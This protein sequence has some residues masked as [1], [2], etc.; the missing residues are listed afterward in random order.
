MTAATG[1]AVGSLRLIDVVL[2]G[3]DIPTDLIVTDGRISA[4]GRLDGSPDGG[5]VGRPSSAQNPGLP[6]IDG[7]GMYAIPGLVDCHAHLDKTL[8]GSPYVPNPGGQDVIEIS[9]HERRVR[10]ARAATLAD[11]VRLLLDRLVGLGTSHIRSHVDIDTEAGLTNFEAVAA[12]R[13]EF[14]D[15]LDIEIVAFPQSGLL[16]RPGTLELMA[17]AMAAGADVVGGLDPAGVD[18]DPS[19]HLD[20][21]FG[22]ATRFSRPIDIHLHDPGELGGWEIAAI[23]ERTRALGMAGMVTISHAMALGEVPPAMLDRLLTG[24]AEQAVAIATVAPGRGLMLPLKR[25]IEAGV[26]VGSGNDGVRGMWAPYGDGDMLDRARVVAYRAGFR[27][28]ADI[29]LALDTATYGGATAM[30]IADYG[31]HLGA[32]ADFLLVPGETR[33]E[34]VVSSPPRAV[35]VKHGHVVAGSTPSAAASVRRREDASR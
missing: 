18:G 5:P 31:L 14:A 29:E 30:R 16:C 13:E 3:S 26:T 32:R 7:A 11:R 8:V 17:E 25:M 20:A 21:I 22:L 28:D 24:L 4:I 27:T 19:A 10:G 6:T 35:V 34:A 15:R 23:V 12:V 9:A 2:P 33:A 1:A